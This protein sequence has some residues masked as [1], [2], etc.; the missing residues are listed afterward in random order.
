MFITFNTLKKAQHY[1]KWYNRRNS[2]NM[3]SPFGGVMSHKMII[4]D[5]LVLTISFNNA[6]SKPL[7]IGKIKNQ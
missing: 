6:G 5:D 2:Y 7:V 1:V 4:S 3:K